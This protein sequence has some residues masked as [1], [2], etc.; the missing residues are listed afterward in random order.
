MMLN[1][2]MCSSEAVP[3]A[4]TGG[5]ADVVGTLP[6]PLKKLGINTIVVM[7]GYNSIFSRFSGI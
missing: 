4:K 3:F 6:I 5:L 2:A 7:P 1:V